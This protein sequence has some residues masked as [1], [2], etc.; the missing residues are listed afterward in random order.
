MYKGFLV[1]YNF[2][3]CIDTLNGVFKKLCKLPDGLRIVIVKLKFPCTWTKLLCHQCKPSYRFRG[4]PQGISEAT[5]TVMGSP[6]EFNTTVAGIFCQ[7]LFPSH[8][9][10]AMFASFRK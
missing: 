10:A 6:S 5:L 7:Y 4:Q 8:T 1:S 3:N 9:L 2:H